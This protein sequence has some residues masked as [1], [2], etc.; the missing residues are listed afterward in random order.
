MPSSFSPQGLCRCCSPLSNS[1]SLSLPSYLVYAYS[2]FSSQCQRHSSVRSSLAATLSH[3]PSDESPS[4]ASCHT[5]HSAHFVCA[6]LI[7]LSPRQKVP[8]ESGP[9]P[10]RSVLCPRAQHSPSSITLGEWIEVPRESRRLMWERL[11]L[12]GVHPSKSLGQEREGCGTPR[13]N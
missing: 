10:Y 3:S 11:D 6:C 5:L 8:G 9:C 12:V 7:S 4:L 1:S 13:R 2:L